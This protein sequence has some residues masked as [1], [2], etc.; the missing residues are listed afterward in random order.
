MLWV[1]IAAQLSEPVGIGGTVSASDAPV[2]LITENRLQ[3]VSI[4]LT[5]KPDGKTQS[6]SIEVSSGN[7]KLDTYTCNLISR[8]AR[9]RAATSSNGTPSYGIF[10]QTMSWWVGNGMPPKVRPPADLY[11]T[12]LKLPGEAKSPVTLQ[13]RAEVDAVG[14][15]SHCEPIDQKLSAGF[16]GVACEQLLKSFKPKPARNYE[17][18]AVPS[19]QNATV[20]FETS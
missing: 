6:C 5:V 16:A 13:V 19:V 2:H 11:L 18:T 4:A 15:V 3:R 14:R 7:P 9:F 8:R 20:L 17:G 1:M 12:V 10:R